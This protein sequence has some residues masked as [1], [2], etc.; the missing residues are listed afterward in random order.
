M[1]RIPSLTLCSLACTVAAEAS[2]TIIVTA[3]RGESPLAEAPVS[4]SVVPEAAI[5]RRGGAWQASDWLRDLPGVAVFGT[6]GGFDGGVIAVRLRGL[7]QRYAAI[8]V[9]GIPLVDGS[10]V[11]GTPRLQLISIPGLERVEVL[12]GAQSGLYGSGAVG[13]VIDY[14]TLRPTAEHR[15]RALASAGSFD[16]YGGELALTGPLGEQAGYAV[17]I[18][19]LS[20]RGFSATTPADDGNPDGYEDDGLQRWAAR[21][22]LEYRHER[23]RLYASAWY[24]RAVQEYDGDYPIDPD[25]G[26]SENRSTFWQ[27]AAGGSLGN[28]QAGLDV[29]LAWSAS[30]TEIHYRDSWNPGAPPTPY[31]SDLGYASLR[32]RLLLADCVRLA[33]GGDA[34]RDMAEIA[35]DFSEGVNQQGLYATV[36]WDDGRTIVEATGR[37]DYHGTYGAHPTG[38]LVGAWFAVPETLKLRAGLASAFRAPSLYQLYGQWPPFFVANPELKPETAWSYEAGID[39]FAE[40]DLS[41]GLT[42]FRSGVGERITYVDPDGW[43]PQPARYQNLGGTTRSQGV[44]LEARAL[45]PFTPELSGWLEGSYTHLDTRDV[46]GDDAPYAPRHAGSLRLGLIEQ[47][48]DWRLRQGLGLRR[49]TPYYTSPDEMARVDGVT[50]W[51]AVLGVSFREQWDFALRGENLS[52]ERY[53]TN[54]TTGPAYSTPPRSFTL[55]VSARF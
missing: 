47:L 52:D 43:G 11:D 39:A 44:E 3:E 8:L 10:A 55:T 33:L 7:D 2:S 13:G 20:S 22:R 37:V 21:G 49:T 54:G 15:Q 18:Q 29:D 4:V 48:G 25:D 12:R 46:D 45:H 1:I 17:A 30:D 19:G 42:A 24:G 26:Y 53:L 5:V 27:A 40:R 14:R 9:D 51:D 38:R 16:S 31:R 6:N 32:G 23:A 35:P 41:L 50:L 34:R 28:R 36:G